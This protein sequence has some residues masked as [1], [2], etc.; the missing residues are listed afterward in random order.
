MSH[1]LMQNRKNSLHNFHVAMRAAWN[2]AA[3]WADNDVKPPMPDALRLKASTLLTRLAG[4]KEIIEASF[5][6]NT[7]S[8][9][10]GP[11][12]GP[13]ALVEDM[14]GGGV[15]LY[16]HG[17]LVRSVGTDTEVVAVRRVAEMI[18]EAA[19]S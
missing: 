8:S 6:D 9:D 15:R 2:A 13:V 4:A 1:V 3:V 16:V 5:P 19:A 7:V 11:S 14:V 17:V 10:T 12:D 18:N